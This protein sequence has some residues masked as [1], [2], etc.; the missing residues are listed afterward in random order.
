LGYEKNGKYLELFVKDN[1]T[2]IS[3]EAQNRIFENFVQE[4]VKKAEK[5]KV[6]RVKRVKDK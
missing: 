1:G 4:E 5:P 3:K 2:D 6:V